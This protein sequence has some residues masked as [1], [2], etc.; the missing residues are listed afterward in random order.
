M[1]R[2]NLVIFGFNAV[3]ATAAAVVAA[4]RAATGGG[5]CIV[6]THFDCKSVPFHRN[7]CQVP[8]DNYLLL[9]CT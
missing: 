6:G 7:L 5:C 4:G 9:L 3:R 1:A 2:F 8:A